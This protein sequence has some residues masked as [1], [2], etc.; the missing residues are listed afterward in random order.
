M[1]APQQAPLRGNRAKIRPLCFALLPDYR[2]HHKRRL[3]TSLPLSLAYHTMS[4]CQVLQHL[5][6]GAEDC[7]AAR[8]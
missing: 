1:V 2:P 3:I 8:G 6:G 7:A 5:H 4:S